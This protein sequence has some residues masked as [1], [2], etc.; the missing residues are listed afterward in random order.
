SKELRPLIPGT[1]FSIEPGIYLPD[2]GY[3]SEI[4]VL[5]SAEGEVVVA[6]GTLQRE[7]F[8]WLPPTH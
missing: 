8:R 4:N 2:L 7:L 6:E 1:L 5:L 3:R